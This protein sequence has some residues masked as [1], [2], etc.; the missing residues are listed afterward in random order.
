M[1]LPHQVVGRDFLLS[2]DRCLLA[3]DTR[4]GKSVQTI[5]AVMEIATPEYAPTVLVVCPASLRTQWR[6]QFAQFGDPSRVRLV[7]A[8]YEEVTKVV[9]HYARLSPDVLVVDESHYLKNRKAKRTQAVFGV[10]AP[11]AKRVWCLSATPAPNDSSELWPMLKALRPEALAHNGRTLDWW[12]FTQRFCKVR[13]TPFGMKIEG[14]RNMGELRERLAPFF[15]RRPAS[16]LGGVRMDD[17]M[18]YLDVS[19]QRLDEL[20][21][22][23]RAE[24]LGWDGAEFERMDDETVARKLDLVETKIKMR[25]SRLTGLA[26]APALGALLRTELESGL[27][28]VVVF[29]W[30]T[31]VV[32]ALVDELRDTRVAALVG[33]TSPAD[34]VRA[35]DLFQTDPDV[36]VFIGNIKAA[37]VGLDL[38]AACE[39]VFAEMSW[40]PGDNKQAAA[41][42]TGLNQKR[43]TRVRYAVMPDSLDERLVRVNRRK[44]EDIRVLVGDA[45]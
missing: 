14:N 44:M 35:V 22:Q 41:R 42:I 16:I 17:E 21:A 40:V 18:L 25:L 1:L 32:D 8:S 45:A 28:K 13:E 26:K 30:H 5:A 43:A 10:V 19:R 11:R 20:K 34:R 33:E 2:H 24:F 4:V 37:G 6:R 9:E 23:L 12:S 36:R 38:S 7:V 3:D 15:L 39:C 29:A 27:D 31:D